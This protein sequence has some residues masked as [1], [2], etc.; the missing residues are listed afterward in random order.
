MYGCMAM[1]DTENLFIM[2]QARA[3]SQVRYCIL[4]P[5]GKG[6]TRTLCEPHELWENDN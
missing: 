2:R 4:F 5:E 3:R 6:L 1:K